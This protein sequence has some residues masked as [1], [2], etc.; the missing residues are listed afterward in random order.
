MKKIFCLKKYEPT[1]FSAD[2]FSVEQKLF[3]NLGQKSISMSQR[4]EKNKWIRMEKWVIH[5][6]TTNRKLACFLNPSSL[7]HDQKAF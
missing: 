3:Q 4:Y 5:I 6:C 7:V 2:L 1:S